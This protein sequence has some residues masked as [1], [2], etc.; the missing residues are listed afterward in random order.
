MVIVVVVAVMVVVVVVD[1]ETLSACVM[2]ARVSSNA[3]AM[4]CTSR[5]RRVHLGHPGGGY[6]GMKIFPS[7]LP[8]MNRLF[9]QILA[10]DMHVCAMMYLCINVVWSCVCM[11][12]Y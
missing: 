3:E 1:V 7:D 11:H 5:V 10:M 8:R 4:P 6:I 9:V 12:L 2:L